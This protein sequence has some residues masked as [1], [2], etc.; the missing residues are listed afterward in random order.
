[1]H[2]LKQSLPADA[3]TKNSLTFEMIQHRFTKT[4]KRVILE[5]YPK[6][7]LEMDEAKR[8]YKWGRWGQG[9]YVYPDEQAEALRVF[10][11]EQIFEKFPQAKIEYFT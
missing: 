8:K 5:R 11:T 10:L 3:E 2:K 4:A 9:K 7:K 1:M 6:T